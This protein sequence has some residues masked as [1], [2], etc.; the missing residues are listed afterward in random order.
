MICYY[1]DTN[2]S[3]R[4]KQTSTQRP[5]APGTD[6]A[7]SIY[8]CA[9]VPVFSGNDVRLLRSRLAPIF[10]AR[11]RFFDRLFHNNDLVRAHETQSW[12]QVRN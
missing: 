4:R 11:D 8:C 3:G 6:P 2:S 12:Y 5:N 9:V 1:L 10:P 7:C